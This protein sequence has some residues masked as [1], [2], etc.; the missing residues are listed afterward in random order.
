[1]QGMYVLIVMTVLIGGYRLL[2]GGTERA[3]HDAAASLTAR[4]MLQTAGVLDRVRAEHNSI[5]ALC[6][7]NRPAT[8][9]P[10]TGPAHPLVHC[11]GHGGRIIVW[12][13]EF[14]GLASALRHQSR[15]SK[16]LA[17]VSGSQ[18]ITLADPARWNV[19]LPAAV[20]NGSLV[21]IK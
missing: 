19:S 21:Y 4:Q 3:E 10:V 17:R 1:M 15:D 9:L 7:G 2:H 14:P 6:P 20:T 16:L 12:A 11:A 18:V 13:T 5:A 8:D